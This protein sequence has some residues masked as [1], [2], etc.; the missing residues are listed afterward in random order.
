MDN[1]WIPGE[2]GLWMDLNFVGQQSEA[3]VRCSTCVD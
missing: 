1:N 3:L 2:A